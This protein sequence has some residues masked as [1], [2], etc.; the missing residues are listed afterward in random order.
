MASRIGGFSRSVVA[1]LVRASELIAGSAPP[2]QRVEIGTPSAPGPNAIKLFVGDGS[3]PATI[4]T[5]QDFAPPFAP[6]LVL[7]GANNPAVPLAP[8]AQLELLA[9][10]PSGEGGNVRLGTTEPALGP[11]SAGIT[12]LQGRRVTMTNR[13]GPAVPLDVA[14][15]TQSSPILLDNSTPLDPPGLIH[16]YQAFSVT[17]VTSPSGTLD[18]GISRATPNNAQI[19]QIYCV[20]GTY[21]V[22]VGPGTLPLQIDSYNTFTVTFGGMLAGNLVRLNVVIFGIFGR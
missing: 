20:I 1:D 2:G 13:D 18:V 4:T 22:P 3:D 5:R 8:P 11:P 9:P 17:G 15:T 16:G 7:A 14:G 6:A 19:K 12:Q 21:G 10:N